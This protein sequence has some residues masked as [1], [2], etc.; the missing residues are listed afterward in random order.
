MDDNIKNK[1]E[2]MNLK[3]KKHIPLT[4]ILTDEQ[5]NN[6]PPGSYLIKDGKLVLR[7]RTKEKTEKKKLKNK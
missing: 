2:G 7:H 3:N 4:A 1:E 6:I 5:R